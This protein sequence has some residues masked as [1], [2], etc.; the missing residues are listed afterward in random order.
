[1]LQDGHR[2]AITFYLFIFVLY[3]AKIVDQ[4]G[5]VP[6][7]FYDKKNVLPLSGYR[8]FDKE[9]NSYQIYINNPPLWQ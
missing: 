7:W 1:M 3:I 2:K 9:N 4:L 8:K 5:K 6:K